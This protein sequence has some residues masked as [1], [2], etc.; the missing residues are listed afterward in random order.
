MK[1]RFPDY[2]TAAQDIGK[3]LRTVRLYPQEMLLVLI[4][5]N[6]YPANFGE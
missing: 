2:T 1:L 3:N 4:S 6:P 5:V